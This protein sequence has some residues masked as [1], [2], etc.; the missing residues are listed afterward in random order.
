MTAFRQ[1]SKDRTGKEFPGRFLQR[2]RE[3]FSS[4]KDNYSK[5]KDRDS[6]GKTDLKLNKSYGSKYQK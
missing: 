2:I 4:G 1:W 6:Y 3:F 5:D